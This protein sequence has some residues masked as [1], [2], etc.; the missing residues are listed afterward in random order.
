MAETMSPRLALLLEAPP[1]RV[2]WRLATPNVLTA[3]LM[4]A[5]TVADAW[6]VGQLGIAALAS[7]ALVFPFQTL[8]QMM[9]GGAI[10]GGIASAVA[11]ALGAGEQARANA[12]AWHAVVIGLTMTA[13]FTL[14]LGVFAR[15]VFGLFGTSGAVLD[16][17]IAYA[18]IA[19]GGAASMWLMQVFFAV[20]RGSGDTVTPARTVMAAS[21]V[22]VGL[23]GALTLGWGPFPALGIVGP[24]VAMVIAL[25]G[26]AAYLGWHLLRAAGMNRAVRI[27]P[28]PLAWA[29]ARAIL[30]VGALGLLNSLTIVLTVVVVTLLV[31]E[32]GTA[33]LAGYG[34]G[35]RLELMLVPLAFGVGGA[36][37]G[38]VGANVGAGRYPRARRLAWTGAAVTFAATGLIGLA[39]ALRPEW[40]LHQ[41]TAD[42]AA[43]AMG[44]LYLMIAGPFYG[45]FGGGQTLY[46]ASQGTG[47][48]LLPVA[49]GF[50]RLAIAAGG[51]L[52][53]ITFGG[54]V[55]ALFACVAAGLATVGIGLA[56]CLFGPG[57]RPR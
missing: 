38:A 17:A 51:G 6:F 27:V 7:L 39:A 41:F 21:L 36:L 42:A 24:A 15:P 50:V 12:I 35:S 10:G 44:S 16:G 43:F 40:W 32:Y 28:Q 53:V 9:A 49:V 54:S 37:T 31:A 18:Q 34:L 19:F 20:L 22:Q 30:Q 56:A 47:R 8:M 3:V 52:L 5:V 29:P 11:R 26:A 4:T 45:L 55:A 25:G 23:S 14:V 46:F 2:L 33:A 57:W 1:S 13:L 48:M